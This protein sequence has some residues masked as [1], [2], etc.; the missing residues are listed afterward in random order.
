MIL[1]GFKR[2]GNLQVAQGDVHNNGEAQCN[3]AC[4]S[5]NNN[6][7]DSAE[8]VDEGRHALF[9]VLKQCG[10]VAR[11]NS[12]EDQSS[13]NSNGHNMGNSRYVVAQRHNAVLNAHLHAFSD[14]LVNDFANQEGHQALILVIADDGGNACSVIGLAQNNGN[15]RNVAGNQRHAQR[16]DDR[17]GNKAN[18]GFVFVRSRIVDPL[19]GLNDFCANSSCQAGVQSCAQVGCVRVQALHNVNAGTQIA[20]LLY[21]YAG[22]GIDGRQEVCGVREGDGG[23]FAMCFD[24][25]GNSAFGQID[26]GIRTAVNHVHQRIAGALCNCFFSCGLCFHGRLFGGGSNLLLC[27]VL[28]FLQEVKKSHF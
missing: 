26:Y 8:R 7:V 5:G 22:S 9:G 3:S 23:I 1:F 16:T 12:A 18:A 24:C 15:A 6:V 10:Q 11:L 20:Q 17:V 19:Q 27:F 21:L 13:T 2:T 25:C 4:T 28:V 14:S